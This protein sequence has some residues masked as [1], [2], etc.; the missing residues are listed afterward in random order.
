MRL[1]LRKLLEPGLSE[2][3][4][5]NSRVLRAVRGSRDVLTACGA[6]QESGVLVR[7]TRAEIGDFD[8][9][10]TLIVDK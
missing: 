2:V 8:G 4:E 5:S 9:T 6:D 1:V 3:P 10:R 7:N